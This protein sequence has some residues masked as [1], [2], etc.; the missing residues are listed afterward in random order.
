MWSDIT[1]VAVHRHV[2]ICGRVK[3]PYDSVSVVAAC[4]LGIFRQNIHSR[5]TMPKFFDVVFY[6]L[7]SGN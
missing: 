2:F 6:L 4:Y 3:A 5:L 1:K 7:G